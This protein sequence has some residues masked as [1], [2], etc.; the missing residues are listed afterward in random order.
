MSPQALPK[1]PTPTEALP[2]APSPR[3]THAKHGASIGRACTGL[4]YSAAGVGLTPV[5]A[6][7]P[8]I[9][10]CSGGTPRGRQSMLPCWGPEAPRVSAT[11]QGGFCCSLLLGRASRSRTEP[12]VQPPSH[13]QEPSSSRADLERGGGISEPQ[14]ACFLR[15]RSPP[16]DGGEG[17]DRGSFWQGP[18]W[19]AD[20]RALRISISGS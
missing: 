7:S 20:F 11:T 3:S 8:Q 5:L 9:S 19:A 17:R 1:V 13:S 4:R 12:P 18:A 14:G 2:R 6:S 16:S 15:V 10:D